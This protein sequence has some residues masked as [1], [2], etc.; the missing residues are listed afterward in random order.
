MINTLMLSR[1]FLVLLA[2]AAYLGSTAISAAQARNPKS[3]E[4]FLRDE[5]WPEA[6]ARGIKRSIFLSAFADI[7]P[8]PVVLASTKTQPEYIKPVG[9]YLESRV[10]P[11]MISSG[12]RQPAHG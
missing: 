9:R 11:E 8:D 12:R 5:L 1:F 3:F 4:L 2:L 6:E 7:S 10:A